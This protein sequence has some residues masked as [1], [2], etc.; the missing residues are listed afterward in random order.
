MTSQDFNQTLRELLRLMVRWDFISLLL[1]REK[2]EE[3][4]K[5]KLFLYKKYPLPILPTGH[6]VFKAK[7]EAVSPPHFS[8]MNFFSLT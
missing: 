7:I 6:L 8:F 4:K 2:E 3:R 1:C 5:S